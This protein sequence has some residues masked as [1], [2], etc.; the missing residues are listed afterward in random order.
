MVV[1]AT[2]PRLEHGEPARDEHGLVGRPQ[3]HA[4]AGYEAEI[5][6]E[7]IRDAIG[8]FE[9]TPVRPAAAR[10]PEHGS[11]AVTVRDPVVQQRTGRIEEAG[12]VQLGH[13][14]PV[15]VRPQLARWQMIPNERIDVS[16]SRRAHWSTWPAMTSF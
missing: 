3:Q 11:I 15:H 1:T 13:A 16:G 2:P 7:N 6:D 14:R 10:I 5:L 8:G 12:I 4:A 9:K